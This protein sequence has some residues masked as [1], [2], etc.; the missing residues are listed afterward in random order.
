MVMPSVLQLKLLGALTASSLLVG[1]DNAAENLEQSALASASEAT[2]ADGRVVV[3]RGAC[4]ASGAVPLDA[5]HFAVA[6]D[7]DSV[8][9]VYDAQRGG[10]PIYSGDLAGNLDLADEKQ[11]R[12]KKKQRKSQRRAPE[13][14]IEAATHLGNRAYWLT[15]H[16]RTK[17]GKRESSRFRFFATELPTK[18]K[19]PKVVGRAYHA[20]VEDMIAAPSLARFKLAGASKLQPQEPGGLNLEGLAGTPDGQLLIGFRNPVPEGKALVVPLENPNEVL[21]GGQARFGAA[22]QLDLSG[23]GVR[24]L[25]WWQNGYLV[26]AGAIDGR[27]KSRLYRWDGK[28]KAKH[29]GVDFGD[30]NP[31]GFFTPEEL[32]KVMVLSDDGSKDVAGRPCKEL[33][34]DDAKSF[35]GIW[36]SLAKS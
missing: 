25:S 20:L 32:T 11:R 6:D 1:C 19:T 13:T 29:L 21:Q 9:R 3:F 26:V 22:S 14:D 36:I 18:G 33:K 10:L 28:G 7:E 17:K 8:L 12:Q 4:D 35:R 23:H 30:L 16:A 15:S 5:R 34:N 27:S 24:A 2:A 31:E